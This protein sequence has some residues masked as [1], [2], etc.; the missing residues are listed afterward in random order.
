ME[1]RERERENQ[2]KSFDFNVLVS[3]VLITKERTHFF[4]VCH[5]IQCRAA[6][7]FLFIWFHWI[8]QVATNTHNVCL[9][10][11]HENHSKLLFE[12]WFFPLTQRR[13]INNNNTRGKNPAQICVDRHLLLFGQR[14]FLELCFF[15]HEAIKWFSFFIVREIQWNARMNSS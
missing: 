7:L 11:I 3:L 5:A 15:F 1:K 6:K 10:L 4:G 8:W 13:K 9:Q 12:N 14:V 2:R